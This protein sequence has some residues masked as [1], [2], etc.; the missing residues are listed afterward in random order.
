VHGSFLA[1][2]VAFVYATGACAL[3]QGVATIYAVIA[4]KTKMDLRNPLTLAVVC[5]GA[6]SALVGLIFSL[7]F[8]VGA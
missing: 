3:I 6:L 2:L 5:V 8:F 4:L 1:F 7:W